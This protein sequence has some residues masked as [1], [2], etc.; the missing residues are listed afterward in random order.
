MEQQDRTYASPEPVICAE[1]CST[2][3]SSASSSS[4]RRVPSLL[5]TLTMRC[6]EEQSKD[7]GEACGAMH[8]VMKVCAMYSSGGKAY[9]LTRICLQKSEPCYSARLL[10]LF[11][12]HFI[13]FR[14][15]ARGID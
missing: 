1:I 2:P 4:D 9:E 6:V 14:V 5:P 15:H 13:R 7:Q 11:Y 3:C 8:N 12:Q 10:N